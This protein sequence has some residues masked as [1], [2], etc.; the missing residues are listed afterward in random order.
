MYCIFLNRVSGLYLL[1]EILTQPVNKPGHWTRLAFIEYIFHKKAHMIVLF[2]KL[3]QL[4]LTYTDVITMPS[5][6]HKFLSIIP[7]MIQFV[8]LSCQYI[9]LL[10]SLQTF[11]LCKE[12]FSVQVRKAPYG[13]RKAPYRAETFA[14]ITTIKYTGK[15]KE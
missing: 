14:E 11:C 12:P 6:H 9:L 1:C 5:I 13:L 15:I 4:L 7:L 3:F 8:L 2:S 10:L